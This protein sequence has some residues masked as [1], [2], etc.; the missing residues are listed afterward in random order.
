[1]PR[2]EVSRACA[3]LELANWMS[4]WIKMTVRDS[5]QKGLFSMQGVTIALKVLPSSSRSLTSG[6]TDGCHESLTL[7]SPQGTAVGTTARLSSCAIRQR[8]ARCIH[9]STRRIR[10]EHP[11]PVFSLECYRTPAQLMSPMLSAREATLSRSSG[12]IY[13]FQGVTSLNPLQIR[14]PEIED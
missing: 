2:L 1:M 11:V 12:A 14:R 9:K 5:R 3:P 6:S 10:L 8:W 7:S 13:K 4:D